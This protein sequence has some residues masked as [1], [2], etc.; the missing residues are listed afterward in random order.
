MNRRMAAGSPACSDSQKHRVINV[1]D[2]NLLAHRLDLCVAAQ[3]KVRVAL[4]E[5]FLIDRAMRIVANDAALTHRR[6]FKDEWPRLVAMTL[7]ATFILPRH[8]Q[9]A[10]R[11]ENVAAMRVM[12]LHA[13]HVAFDDR[14][15]LRQIKLRVDVE[16]TLKAGSRIFARVDDEISAAAGLDVFAAR[17]VAGFAAGFTDH[18][19]IFKMNPRMR[20]GGKFSD[21]VLVAIR[22]GLV[23]DVMRAGNFQ[24]HHHRA[25]GGVA[26]SQK[27]RGTG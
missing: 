4:D 13:A 22:A 26:R 9:S 11:L 15:M 17:P 19:R 21:D 16:M 23:T 18:R 8:G 2:V 10:R 27:E 14:M 24:R 12:A 3:A 20:A 5:H 6:M 7:R 1:A 25:R